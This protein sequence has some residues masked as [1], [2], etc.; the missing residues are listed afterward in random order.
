MAYRGCFGRSGDGASFLSVRAR[1][2][3]GMAEC[4]CACICKLSNAAGDDSETGN[5]ERNIGYAR[6]SLAESGSFK[7]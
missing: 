2:C 7:D 4:V 5:K 6:R 1:G 3:L